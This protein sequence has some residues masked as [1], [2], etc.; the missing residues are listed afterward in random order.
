MAKHASAKWQ[1]PVNG[2]PNGMAA[3]KQHTR[4]GPDMVAVSLG[5]AP[6]LAREGVA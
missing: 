4:D 5:A 6:G 1:L 2:A 3:G